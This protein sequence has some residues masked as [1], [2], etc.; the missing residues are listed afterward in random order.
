MF[1]TT[2]IGILALL[3]GLP[4]FASGGDPGVSWVETDDGWKAVI[5][6]SFDPQPGQTLRVQQMIGGMVFEAGEPVLTLAFT[7]DD[8]S[9]EEA[10]ALLE[11]ELPT[12]TANADGYTLKGREKHER[13]DWRF[14]LEAILPS[15]YSLN[16]GTAA[17]SIYAEGLTGEFDFSSGGGSIELVKL[18]GEIDASSGGGGID[19][20]HLTGDLD[21]STGGGGIDLLHVSGNI[22]AST[23]GGG[24]SIRETQADRISLSTGGGELEFENVT[25]NDF[26]NAGTGGGD[27][28]LEG[29]T[30]EFEV[31]TGAGQI[32]VSDHTGSIDA[33]TGVGD[34]EI[35]ESAC[36]VDVSTGMGRI[37]VELVGLPANGR[38]RLEMS[39]GNGNIDL[40]L[41]GD[42]SY[43]F[44]VS[45][46]RG[47]TIK[48][49]FALHLNTDED[50]GHGEINGGEVEVEMSANGRVRIKKI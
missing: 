50:H 27:I 19:G 46:G 41:P 12:L 1:R 28:E 38:A 10:E 9:R 39:S 11:K 4:C 17:G 26:A 5:E 31:S 36:W 34:I 47:G 43:A 45:S 32:E 21:L 6:Y 20:E 7:V 24:S 25:V 35:E 8:M 16:A 37:E 44:E 33:S 15:E 29:C 22:D 14:K 40:S 48:S 13:G 18:T 23:G 42:G 49:D 3:I 30:G 2:L